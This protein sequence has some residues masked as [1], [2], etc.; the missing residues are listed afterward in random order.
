MEVELRNIWTQGPTRLQD[1]VPHHHFYL[2]DF[3]L[4][5]QLP[6]HAVVNMAAT[7][8]W[9]LHLETTALKETA[10]TSPFAPREDSYWSTVDHVSFTGP[11]NWGQGWWALFP[12]PPLTVTLFCGSHSTRDKLSLLISTTCLPDWHVSSSRIDTFLICWPPYPSTKTILQHM[13]AT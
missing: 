3:I 7:G 5:H 8:S 12:P 11:N 10:C 2:H 1:S 4:S 9:I 13:R 6:L